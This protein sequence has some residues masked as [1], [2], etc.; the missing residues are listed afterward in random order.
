M[1]EIKKPSEG[2]MWLIKELG[3]ESKIKKPKVPVSK[4]RVI[5]RGINTEASSVYI[6]QD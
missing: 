5:Y 4:V 2:A 3:L 1:A 6:I